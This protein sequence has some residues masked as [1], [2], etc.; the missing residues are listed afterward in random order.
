[1]NTEA[2]N[3]LPFPPPE[4]EHATDRMQTTLPCKTEEDI[5]KLDLYDPAVNIKKVDQH[6]A[7]YENIKKNMP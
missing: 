4:I 7:I 5:G 1:M 2:S 3:T 6:E